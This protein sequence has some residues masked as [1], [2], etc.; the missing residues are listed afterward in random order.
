MLFTSVKVAQ[1]DFAALAL[2]AV[3]HWAFLFS[4]HPVNL[5]LN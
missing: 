5:G 4:L 1:I 2:R 3:K